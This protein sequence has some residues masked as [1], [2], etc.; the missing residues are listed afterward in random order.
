M[1][2][3]FRRSSPVDS[4]RNLNDSIA[5]ITPAK[6]QLAMMILTRE[7]FNLTTYDIETM[8]YDL[9]QTVLWGNIFKPKSTDYKR[10][11]SDLVTRTLFLLLEKEKTP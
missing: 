4:P 8:G 7:K 10:W 9:H 3:H 1:R 11:A 6:L 2:R 5:E